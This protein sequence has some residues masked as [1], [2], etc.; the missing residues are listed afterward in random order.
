MEKFE[1]FTEE[2]LQKLH[3]LQSRQKRVTRQR[4]MIIS[5]IDDDSELKDQVINHLHQEDRLCKIAQLYGTDSDT[6]Y[7]MLTDEMQIKSFKQNYMHAD[8]GQVSSDN[9]EIGLT[10][11]D[12]I[13]S[14][15]D[16]Y[17]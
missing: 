9:D 14:N 6:L 7:A 15:S 5:A 2:D 8:E 12:N 10:E 11:N 3:E 4:K 13:P 1:S 17:Y 16:D